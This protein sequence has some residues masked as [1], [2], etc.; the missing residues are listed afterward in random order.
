MIYIIAIKPVLSDIQIATIKHSISV[1]NANGD[2]NIQIIV[3][4]PFINFCF[5]KDNKKLYIFYEIYLSY[6]NRN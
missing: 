6:K 1:P 2:N 5:Y 3:N 4:K